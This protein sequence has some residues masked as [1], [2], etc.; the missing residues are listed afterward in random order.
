[1]AS[2]SRFSS[3][4]FSARAFKRAARARAARLAP[5]PKQPRR[6]PPHPPPSLPP[7][8]SYALQVDTL[9]DL[10]GS[11]NF[12]L[13]ALLSYFGGGAFA[14]GDARALALTVLAC[15]SRAE[16][17]AFLLYRVLRRK[18]DER[19]DAIRGSL[20]AFFAFWV[21]QM[22]WVWGVSLPVVFVNAG[23]GG[24]GGGALG[25]SDWAGVAIFAAAF[26]LQ[27]AADLQKDAFR[28]VAANAGRVCDAGVWRWSRHPNF[29]GE[30]IMWW[31][32]LLL[33]AGAF[34][35]EPAGWA[36]AASPLL[37]MLI[38]LCGS[39]MPTAEGDN[40]LRFMRT[41]EA[42]AAFAAYRNR[43]SPLVPLPNAL[44]AR[45]PLGVKR[46]LLF[47]WERYEV[48]AQDARALL[49]PAAKK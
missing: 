14:R 48:T 32:V 19:F 46:W 44:Y 27:V 39:G 35:A 43:T 38:L 28:A 9:T 21:F 33:A 17:G 29:A 30:I 45:L 18:K 37:T 34:A 22:V 41:P 25:A 31:A 47:E 3:R 7:S 16:L 13:L 6:A 8:P 23:G 40:Q 12:I 5:Q 49:N 36:T 24:G 2:P 10:A 4:A 1:M 42:A 11:L 20:P 15:V 26:A